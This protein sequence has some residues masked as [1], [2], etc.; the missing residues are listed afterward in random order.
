MV[1]P[2]E[3][4]VRS[5]ARH[6][7]RLT[8]GESSGDV[9]RLPI[10][11][12]QPDAHQIISY[13]NSLVFNFA[14]NPALREFTVSFLGQLANNDVSRQISKIVRFVRSKIIYVADPV[15]SE[16][17]ISPLRL[18]SLVQIKGYAHGDCDDHVLLLNSM[19]SAVG[20]KTMA[21]GVKLHRRDVFDHVISGVW[22]DNHWNYIDPCAKNGQQ[23]EYAE[24]LV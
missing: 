3:S 22:F 23:P 6:Q 19:L 16:Y 21:V 13:L 4:V 12:W 11:N 14:A 9:I 2:L 8:G 20:V 24:K 10:N 18:I 17:I 7:V 1:A 15:G 5:E